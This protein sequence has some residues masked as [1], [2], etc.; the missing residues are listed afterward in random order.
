MSET[1]LLMLDLGSCKALKGLEWECI[2]W[3]SKNISPIILI[4][5]KGI[6][7]VVEK[8]VEGLQKEGGLGLM[9]GIGIGVTGVVLKV[10]HVVRLSLFFS[11]LFLL[12]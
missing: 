10:R 11:S 2:R 5:S 1:D 12:F 7:G 4:L 9:K 3:V 8:P 6:T